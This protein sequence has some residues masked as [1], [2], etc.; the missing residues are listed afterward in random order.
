MRVLKELLDLTQVS[1]GFQIKLRGCRRPDV[2]QRERRQPVTFYE[3]WEVRDK[4]LIRCRARRN[5]PALE[6]GVADEIEKQFRA[7][8]RLS[9][10]CQRLRILPQELDQFHHAHFVPAIDAMQLPLLF[11]GPWLIPDT[12]EKAF[13]ELMRGKAIPIET[14]QC[15][16]IDACACRNDH[17]ERYEMLSACC[18]LSQLVALPDSP[19]IVLR[20]SQDLPEVDQRQSPRL[21]AI[22]IHSGKQISR[23]RE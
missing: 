10:R 15:S 9:C 8:R 14:V 1:A 16:R 5:E 12:V 18:H 13:V 21:R 19:D 6:S 2:H 22:I 7:F 23:R 3:L 17:H 11:P 4:V 20:C